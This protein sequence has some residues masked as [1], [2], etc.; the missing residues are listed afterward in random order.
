V[1]QEH[2]YSK[3]EEKIFTKE[4]KQDLHTET[5]ELQRYRNMSVKGSLTDSKVK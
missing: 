1:D 2:E 4:A 3:E 5:V